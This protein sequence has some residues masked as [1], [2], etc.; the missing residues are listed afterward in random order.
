MCSALCCCFPCLSSEGGSPTSRPAPDVRRHFNNKGAGRSHERARRPLSRSSSH[1][2]ARVHGKSWPL[3]KT[4][5]LRHFVCASPPSSPYL[6]HQAASSKL[7]RIFRV[8]YRRKRTPHQRM[9]AEEGGDA[10]TGLS[11][12]TET[13]VC[14]LYGDD[15]RVDD[16]RGVCCRWTRV[17]IH[18]QRLFDLLF[19]GFQVT[20]STRRG[21]VSSC[22]ERCPTPEL[23]LF[24]REGVGLT[25]WETEG[26]QLEKGPP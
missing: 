7:N 6:Q 26:R 24:H 23:T 9:A 4:L 5:R 20:E 22:C 18:V 8:T 21:Q 16:E 1:T 17:K 25:V 2:H 10:A 13:S 15:E 12:A 14:R 11:S 3:Q 19:M